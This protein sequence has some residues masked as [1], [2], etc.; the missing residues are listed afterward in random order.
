MKVV[1]LRVFFYLK[2]IKK[3]KKRSCEV[4]INVLSL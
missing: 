4:E 1:E 2:K 3:K